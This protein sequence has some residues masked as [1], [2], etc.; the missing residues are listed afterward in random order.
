MLKYK[1]LVLDH[2][3]TVMQS[4]KTLCYPC[5]A[6]TMARLR[7]GISVTL[8]DYIND[9]HTMG[10]YDMCKVKYGF[11][12]REMAEEYDD[13]KAYIRSHSAIPFDGI[14]ECIR[15]WKQL[16]GIICVVSHS[17]EEIILR[18]YKA[19]IG[20]EPDAIFGCD[21]PE[22]QQKPNVYPLRAIM[23]QYALSPDELL[24]LDDSKIGYDMAAAAGVKTA[25]AAWSKD[26]FENVMNQM[27][28]LCDFT[29]LTVA[30]FEGF[31]FS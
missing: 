14:A 1:C 10:F 18:D 9:C 15:R 21:Y 4:E 19:H 29:F 8:E 24:V 16:G 27:R 28:E 20:I 6:Q 11:N 5:F 23:E 25:F 7:P 3:D 12:D 26:G 2:D 31:L 17:S 22:A 13:W 30:D